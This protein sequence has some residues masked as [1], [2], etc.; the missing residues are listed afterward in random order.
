MTKKLANQTDGAVLNNIFWL[1]TPAA[2]GRILTDLGFPY[3]III[4][5]EDSLL[6]LEELINQRYTDEGQLK[7]KADKGRLYPDNVIASKVHMIAERADGVQL[8]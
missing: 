3:S 7:K 1:P 5:Y 6:S 8:V 4:G 2:V